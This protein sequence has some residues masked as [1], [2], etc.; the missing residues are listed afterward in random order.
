MRQRLWLKM[1]PQAENILRS[2]ARECRK[3]I[4]AGI[5]GR[6][7]AEHDAIISACLDEYEGRLKSVPLKRFSARMW[8]AYYVRLIGREK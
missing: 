8:L 7:A 4:L 6:P 1:A 5:K 2:V 3:A